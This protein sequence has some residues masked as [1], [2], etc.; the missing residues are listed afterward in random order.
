MSEKINKY[1]LNQFSFVYLIDRMSWKKSFKNIFFDI[2][3]CLQNHTDA[4]KRVTSMEGQMYINC[5]A[6]F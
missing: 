6:L 5:I 4:F 3:L 1:Y 2:F